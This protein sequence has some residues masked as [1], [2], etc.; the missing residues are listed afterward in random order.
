MWLLPQTV[1]TLAVIDSPYS[2]NIVYSDEPRCLGRIS[3]RD[4]RF[5]RERARLAA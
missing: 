1:A 2:D 4:G 3:C 5:Y